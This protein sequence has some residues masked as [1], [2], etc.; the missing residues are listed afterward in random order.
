MV[1]D[2]LYAS[3]PLVHKE[4]VTGHHHPYA[5]KPRM[6][7]ASSSRGKIVDD[8]DENMSPTQSETNDEPRRDN[9][10]VHEQGAQ[11]NSE[12]TQP[13]NA[14]FPEYAQSIRDETEKEPGLQSSQC[15]K[16]CKPEGATKMAES[17]TSRKCSWDEISC[18]CP[19]SVPTQSKG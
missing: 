8:K 16:T 7:H 6:G 5:C 2:G 9:L 11:S 17:R 15:G 12:F 4:K 14:P 18:T 13:S 10:T 19:L 1:G 3:L